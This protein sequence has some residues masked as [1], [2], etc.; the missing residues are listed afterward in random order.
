METMK[1]CDGFTT[2]QLLIL[3]SLGL[4]GMLSNT[5]SLIYLKRNFLMKKPTNQVL[6]MDSMSNIIGRLE[7]V[8]VFHGF[9]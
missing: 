7:L 8:V 2:N 1:N 3:F 5:S 9:G 6:L 4:C